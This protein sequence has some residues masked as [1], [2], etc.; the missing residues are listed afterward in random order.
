MNDKRWCFSL[1]SGELYEIELEEI[2]NLDKYQIV[3]K[4]KPSSSCN[5]CYG[6]FYESYY[7]TAQHFDICKKCGKKLIDFDLIKNGKAAN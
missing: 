2:N 7:S 6:R 4:S 1:K 5:K 3:L